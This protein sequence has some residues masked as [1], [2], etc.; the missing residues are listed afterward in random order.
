MRWNKAFDGTIDSLKEKSDKPKPTERLC[1][2]LLSHL[3]QYLV[4]YV[5]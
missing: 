4:S 3:I 1:G 2:Y 5:L